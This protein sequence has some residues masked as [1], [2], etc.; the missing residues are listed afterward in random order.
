M[1]PKRSQNEPK[2]LPKWSQEASKRRSKS[3]LDWK[4]RTNRGPRRML[5]DNFKKEITQTCLKETCLSKWTGSA[6]N[7]RKA[8]KRVMKNWRSNQRK[9][10]ELGA[11]LGGF[12]TILGAI[13]GPEIAQKEFQKWDQFWKQ[14]WS[15]FGL[16]LGLSWGTSACGPPAV[17]RA[18]TWEG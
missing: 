3:D 13:F 9:T 11:Y 15:Y 14:F 12:C 4:K 2:S 5:K 6:L 7:F 16:V 8:W 18:R 10:W 1:L 17:L